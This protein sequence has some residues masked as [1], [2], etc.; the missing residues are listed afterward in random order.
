M[1]LSHSS[2][3]F[4]PLDLHMR[5]FFRFL[6][7]LPI[8]QALGELHGED[9]TSELILSLCLGLPW[10]P[11]FRASVTELERVLPG[12]VQQSQT[13]NTEFRSEKIRAVYWQGTKPGEG[14]TIA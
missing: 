9:P 10:V 12:D 4:L 3:C 1:S 6:A 7:L 13:L 8:F 14:E 11:Y 5:G 2:F